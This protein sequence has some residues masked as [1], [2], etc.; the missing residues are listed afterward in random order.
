MYN[1]FNSLQ[2]IKDSSP[3]AS[4]NTPFGYDNHKKFRTMRLYSR[5]DTLG[6]YL[7][8]LESSYQFE[9]G[10]PTSNS[11]PRNKLKPDSEQ[12]QKAL[13]DFSFALLNS[14]SSETENLSVKREIQKLESDYKYVMEKFLSK[15]ENFL[16]SCENLLADMQK[17][18]GKFKSVSR[19]TAQVTLAS[20]ALELSLLFGSALQKIFHFGW[21]PNLSAVETIGG[22]ASIAVALVALTYMRWSSADITKEVRDENNYL[23]DLMVLHRK[24]N[25]I[26]EEVLNLF[27]YGINMK[28]LDESGLNNGMPYRQNKSWRHDLCYAILLTNTQKDVKLLKDDKFL[29]TLKMFVRSHAAEIWWNR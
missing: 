20:S 17:T 23:M 24:G 12:I 6:D 21:N 18:I 5:D 19:I 3:S 9:I 10:E 27:P 11:N 26:D 7:N 16:Y 22:S 4:V 28:L 2:L 13:L 25:W 14:S 15:M 29:A 8:S 1:S